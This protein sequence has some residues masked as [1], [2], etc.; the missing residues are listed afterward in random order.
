MIRVSIPGWH[1]LELAH[2][3]LDLNGTIA[4]DGQV[5]P[6]VAERLA[7]LSAELTVHLVTADTQGQA[8]Q[9]A[10]RLG[11]HLFRIV[12]GDEV[13]QKLS[14]VAQL[15]PAQTV[16]IGNGAND[17]RMLAAAVLGIAVLGPEG[18]ATAALQ[19][20]E[21]VTRRIEDALDL[22]LCPKRLVA[23]LRR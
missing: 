4:L 22:L 10:E 8:A 12:P 19:A 7:A 21:V 17:A 16:A 6:G 23:T 15:G 14:L 11:L 3:V 18:L 13:G 20:A 5:L 2:L 9:S 1:T